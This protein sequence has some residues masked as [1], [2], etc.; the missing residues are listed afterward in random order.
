[1]A[2]LL[3]RPS[4]FPSGWRDDGVGQLNAERAQERSTAGKDLKHNT[5]MQGECR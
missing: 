1:M 4:R 2:C 3:L 5:T